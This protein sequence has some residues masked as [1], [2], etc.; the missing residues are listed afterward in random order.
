MV[1]TA[2]NVKDAPGCKGS[3]E[4]GLPAH[5]DPGW[6]QTAWLRAVYFCS[7]FEQHS[8]SLE[9]HRQQ[10]VSKNESKSILSDNPKAQSRIS[11]VYRA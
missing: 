6:P 1:I 7:L 5:S 11:G 2:M 9:V 4:E 3:S 10:A 8:E